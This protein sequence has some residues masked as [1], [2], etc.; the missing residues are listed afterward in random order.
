MTFFQ[1]VFHIIL[2]SFCILECFKRHFS[3]CRCNFLPSNCGN[4]DSRFSGNSRH[5][6]HLTHLPG[7]HFPNDS[8]RTWVV[9]RYTGKL[10]LTFSEPWNLCPNM[11]L[12][13][14]VMLGTSSNGVFSMWLSYQPWV[15]YQRLSPP[16]SK[17]LRSGPVWM[18]SKWWC[19]SMY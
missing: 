18:V 9:R 15:Y 5:S 10:K 16:T 3:Q 7:T 17:E 1:H 8:W 12:M 11:T 4:G 19:P 13:D 14:V 6:R 2:L